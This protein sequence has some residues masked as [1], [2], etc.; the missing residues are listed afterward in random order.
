MLSDKDKREVIESLIRQTEA[1]IYGLQVAARVRKSVGDDTNKL[2]EQ[3]EKLEKMLD[4]YR[5]E[6]DA[7]PQ[8]PGREG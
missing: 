2:I 6:L 4:G 7:V 8:E 5:A 1:D 3:L